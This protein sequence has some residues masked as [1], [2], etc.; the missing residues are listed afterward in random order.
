MHRVSS[1]PLPGKHA[2]PAWI[3]TVAVTAAVAVSLGAVAWVY[4]D[5]ASRLFSS[6]SSALAG[7]LHS[8]E[9]ITASLLVKVSL[10]PETVLSS[11]LALGGLVAID[12][13]IFRVR[14][15]HRTISLLM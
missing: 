12:Q 1:L 9:T 3:P 4:P 2:T 14:R 11:I 15:S 13:L 10:Q 5:A 7:S 8:I 6:F